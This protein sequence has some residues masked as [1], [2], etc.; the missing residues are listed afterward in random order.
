MSFVEKRTYTVHIGKIGEYLKLY[1]EEGLKVQT[2]IL[3]RLVGYFTSEIGELNQ[4]IHMW[5][6]DSLDQRTE[7][8][9]QLFADPAWIAYVGK[10]RPLIIRQES[11]ILIPTPWSPVK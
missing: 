5:G 10:V 7:K 2:R 9:K 3:P 6:Y 1:E 4:I 8:R 11:Q